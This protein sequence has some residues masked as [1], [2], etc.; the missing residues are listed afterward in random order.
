[1][2][3]N[4]QIKGPIVD[5]GTK[6][7]Y[8]YLGMSAT[9]PKSVIDQLPDDGSEV[10]LAINS[11]GG[12]VDAGSEIYTALRDYNGTVT[13]EVHG[14]AA[15]AA[16]IIAMSADKIIMS[17]VAQ[18]MIHNAS[19]FVGGNTNDMAHAAAMLKTADEALANAY[20][21]KTGKSK[22]EVLDLMNQE[23]WFNAEN[24]IEL[25]FADEMMF[26]DSTNDDLVAVA[27]FVDIISDDTKSQI[28]KLRASVPNIQQPTFDT[29]ELVNKVVEAIKN[30]KQIIDEPKADP[31]TENS[32]VR[33]AF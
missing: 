16:S 28:M 29:D 25:G 4:I 3:T 8:D 2:T 9:G 17:P 6:K 1:M 24:A 31:K 21:S 18:M 30:Q 13:A 32:L 22:A 15:S 19:T 10:V 23:T 11:P 27:S 5:D 26:E 20:V 33:F 12:M 7:F 14:L